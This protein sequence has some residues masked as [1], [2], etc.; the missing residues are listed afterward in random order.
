MEM[1]SVPTRNKSIDFVAPAKRIPPGS[2]LFC[3]GAFKVDWFCTVQINCAQIGGVRGSVERPRMWDR[4]SVDN[5]LITFRRKVIECFLAEN[6][7]FVRNP[8]LELASDYV[9]IE[10]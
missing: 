5:P 7:K 1:H 9:N 6:W 4:S 3:A 10:V 2:Y 8:I